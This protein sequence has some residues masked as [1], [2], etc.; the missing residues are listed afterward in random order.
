M[1]SFNTFVILVKVLGKKKKKKDILARSA[2]G[3]GIIHYYNYTMKPDFRRRLQIF[4]T[5]KLRLL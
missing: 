2:R 4:D 3:P 1:A 5:L